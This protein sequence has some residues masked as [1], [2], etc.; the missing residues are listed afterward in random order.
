M[1]I[2][3][4]KINRILKLVRHW[5][6]IDIQNNFDWLHFVFFLW[7]FLISDNYTR[8]DLFHQGNSSAMQASKLL[9]K[10]VFHMGPECARR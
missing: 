8:I 1:V 2:K 10:R 7:F 4:K 9:M 5:N 3:S 6:K